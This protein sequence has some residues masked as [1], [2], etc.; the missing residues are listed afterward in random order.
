MNLIYGGY[1]PELNKKIG[2]IGAG[3]MAEAFIG[4]IIKSNILPPSMIY[5]ADIN[6]DRLVFLES[7]YGISYFT[8]NIKLFSTCDIIVLAVKPQHIKQVLSQISGQKDYKIHSRKMIVSIAAGISLQKI[9]DF[10]YCRKSKIFFMRLLM[11][12]PGLIFL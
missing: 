9:E 2:F 7:S 4:A 11:K 1:M 3:N 10:L 5:A 8:D 6:K 12:N